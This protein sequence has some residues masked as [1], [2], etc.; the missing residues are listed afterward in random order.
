[1]EMLRQWLPSS[2]IHWE[3]KMFPYFPTREQK[4]VAKL[5]F[6]LGQRYRLGLPV[7]EL[8]LDAQGRNASLEP[9]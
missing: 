4:R 6:L 9:A 8:L 5:A 2:R 3:R 1:M 7:P